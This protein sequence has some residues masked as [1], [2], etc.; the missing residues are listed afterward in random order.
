MKFAEKL[1]TGPLISYKNIKRQIYDAA[2][3]DYKKWLTD[4]EMAT[5]AE[6]ACTED[7]KEGVKAFIEKRKPQFSGR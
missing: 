6:C 7:F 5:Q 4:T 1:A 3:A 2:Y